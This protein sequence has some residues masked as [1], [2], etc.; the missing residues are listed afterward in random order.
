MCIGLLST[1]ICGKFVRDKMTWR[2]KRYLKEK[3][4]RKG[5]QERL[6]HKI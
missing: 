6:K 4:N 2:R 1:I 3:A 5:D